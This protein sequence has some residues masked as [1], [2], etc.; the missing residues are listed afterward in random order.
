MRRVQ[1]FLAISILA[2]ASSP[3][4]AVTFGPNLNINGST[5]LVDMPGALML[6][7]GQ[8]SWSFT[9]SNTMSGTVLSFQ[10]LPNIEAVIRMQNLQD[11]NGPGV[12]QAERSLDLK[13]QLFG[14]QGWRPAV[15]VGFTDFGANGPLASE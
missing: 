5:G 6:P 10:L 3:A 14:E 4:A 12:N 8:T 1:N 13:F 2:L 15:A 7:D 11:W 9:G